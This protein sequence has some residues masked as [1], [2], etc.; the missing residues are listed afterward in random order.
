MAACDGI[1]IGSTFDCA[2]PVLILHFFFQELDRSHECLRRRTI[3]VTGFKRYLDH[4]C[5]RFRGVTKCVR[6]PTSFPGE[7]GVVDSHG[8]VGRAS[9]ASGALIERP[10]ELFHVTIEVFGTHQR[11]EQL[12]GSGVVFFIHTSDEI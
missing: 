2:D 9:P 1:T 12:P 7:N 5:H 8:A 10:D 11:P 4:P 3:G 6:D